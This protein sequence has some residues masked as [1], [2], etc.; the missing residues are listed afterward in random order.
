MQRHCWF[1]KQE[2]LL[3]NKQLTKCIAMKLFEINVENLPQLIHHHHHQQRFT[4]RFS[5]IT[6]FPTNK[7]FHAS[8][9]SAAS[10]VRPH[11]FKS[12]FTISV[13]HT[14]FYIFCSTYSSQFFLR[15]H[16]PLLRSQTHFCIH[17][18]LYARGDQTIFKRPCLITSATHNTLLL[19]QFLTRYPVLETYPTLKCVWISSHQFVQLS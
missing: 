19:F 9:S 8:L 1:Q 17:T 11:N 10:F 6:L 12:S 15:L 2:R 7:T 16:R 14:L 5:M 3:R 18:F 13:L 4:V